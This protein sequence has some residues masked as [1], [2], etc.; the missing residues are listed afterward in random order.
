MRA[1]PLKQKKGFKMLEGVTPEVKSS[2]DNILSTFGGEDGGLAFVAFYS[3]VEQLDKQWNDG[4]DAAG[5]LLDIIIKFNRLIEI[6]NN[7][8]R[9]RG[10]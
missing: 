9:A 2:L 1:G 3:L 4:D 10:D 7:G 6:A 5:Q 8:K